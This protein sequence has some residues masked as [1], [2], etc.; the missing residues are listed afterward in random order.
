MNY[1]LSFRKVLNHPNNKKAKINT[2]GRLFLWKL[3]QLFLH[4]PVTVDLTPEI[5]CVCHP[6]S[7]FGSL[8]VYTKFP[9]YAEMNFLYDYL[10]K[11]DIF[12]DVGAN[13]GAYSLIAASKIKTGKIFSFEP[14]PKALKYL[15]ENIQI[16]NIKHI[17]TIV[18][19]V[20][21]DKNGFE[22]FISGKHSEVDRIGGKSDL[23]HKIKTIPSI[24]L[25]KFLTIQKIPYVDLI[26]IDIEGAEL[27]AL[28]GL[29]EFL[30]RDKVGAILFEI[31]SNCKDYG[32]V[33]DDIFHFLENLG[34]S[35]YSFAE[36]NKIKKLNRNKL[37][38]SLMFNVLAVNKI[39]RTQTRIK[40]IFSNL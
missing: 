22:K 21:S 30:V 39:K 16:N 8:I 1:L 38:G 18:D 35:L 4:K 12:V 15:K 24:T 3:N 20:V 27:K 25:D 6:D 23:F 7:S 9:E 40:K 26:K 33:E 5:K 34:F 14:S 19:K 29:R 11:D 36:E 32:Y 2:L 31:N 28:K 37:P 13:I 17:V 10:E